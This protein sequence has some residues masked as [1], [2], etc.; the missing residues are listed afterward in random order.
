MSNRI[1]AA[2]DMRPNREYHYMVR[3]RA[4]AVQGNS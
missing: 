2:T 1:A 3:E 4:G